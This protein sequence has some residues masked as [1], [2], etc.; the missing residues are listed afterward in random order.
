M[1]LQMWGCD[2]RLSSNACFT[3][4]PSSLGIVRNDIYVTLV[5]GEFD[6]GKKKTPKNVEVMVSVLD[7][8]GNLMEVTASPPQSSSCVRPVLLM[9][10]LSLPVPLRWCFTVAAV[11]RSIEQRSG[12]FIPLRWCRKRFSQGLATMASRSTSR[13]FI[14]KSSSRAGMRQSR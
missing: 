6:R 1:V 4:I 10:R 2:K 13:S 7:N 8:E 3:T 5:Q 12:V 11:G 9:R 14:T